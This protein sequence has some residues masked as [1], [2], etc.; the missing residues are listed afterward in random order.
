MSDVGITAAPAFVTAQLAG[1]EACENMIEFSLKR[2]L[3]EKYQPGLGISEIKD[4]LRRFGDEV[5]L[6]RSHPDPASAIA[7]LI[8][9]GRFR[10][11]KKK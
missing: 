9:G 1:T 2:N 5:E 6:Y 11:L 8:E 3:I 7:L 10:I 4:E